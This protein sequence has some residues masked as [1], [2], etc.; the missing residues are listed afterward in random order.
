MARAL[1][2]NQLGLCYVWLSDGYGPQTRVLNLAAE[3]LSY[4]ATTIPEVNYKSMSKPKKSRGTVRRLG[5]LV[6]KRVY[7]V[8]YSGEFHIILVERARD[9]FL[10]VLI[11][12]PDERINNLEV[13]K[14]EGQ[15]LL[16][17]SSTISGNAH[18]V[19]DWYFIVERGVPKR[20][21]YDEVLQAELKK[22]LPENVE[23]HR[24]GRFDPN[25]LTFR[26]DTTCDSYVEVVFGLRAGKFYVK[27]SKYHKAD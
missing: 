15:D 12:N 2:A 1:D 6:G 16:V 27:S 5:T 9:R 23:I 19:D 8:K 17:Y 10:P 26:G 24:G 22:V 13:R 18:Y 11:V 20:I 21:Q 4:Y 25:T 14:V 3:P 7:D